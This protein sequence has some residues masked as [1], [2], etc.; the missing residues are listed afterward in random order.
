MRYEDDIS[1]EEETE[2]QG[3]RFSFQN[4]HKGRQKSSCCKKS[5]GKKAAFSLRQAAGLFERQKYYRC[6]LFDRHLF[7]YIRN[8][9]RFQLNILKDGKL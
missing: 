4:E 6:R 9:S 1:A 5:K 2:S 8:T 3:S 7:F